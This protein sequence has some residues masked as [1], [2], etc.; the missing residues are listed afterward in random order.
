[1]A[2]S[3]KMG[4]GQDSWWRRR[5]LTGS[6]EQ[7][8]LAVLLLL[9]WWRY[10]PHSTSVCPQQP[11]QT[12][13]SEEL[14]VSV[15][16]PNNVTPIPSSNTETEPGV[17]VPRPAVDSSVVPRHVWVAW[18]GP[19]MQGPRLEGFHE[20]RKNLGV[21][22]TVLTEDNL[23]SFNIKEDPM[24]PAVFENDLS[25]NHLVDYLRV[26][27]MHHYG[28]GYHDIKPNNGS[29]ARSFNIFEQDPNVWMYGI[30]E[31]GPYG[32]ACDPGYAASMNTT[33]DLV[34]A[35]WKGLACNGAYIMRPKT[36]MT[37]A[38]LRIVNERLSSKYEQL[39]K[40]PAPTPRCC[41]TWLGQ[42]AKGYPFQWA[43]MHGG[44]FHPVQSRYLGHIRHGL[45][46]WEMGVQYRSEQEV[47]DQYG[48][49]GI[50][51]AK[52]A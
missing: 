24:H 28:G 43:E 29:W 23:A 42:D 48:Q 32:V 50:N 36:A 18:F 25:K 37:A 7:K 31:F 27:F 10:M 38:W 40:H 34:K 15:Q 12:V 1:M 45:H 14:A 20:L 11:S 19:P 8:L 26:Y 51:D 33:C 52:K 4:S 30:H 21:N 35:S 46:P 5:G 16:P 2:S 3:M 44:A 9:L 41:T 49:K 39:K 47:L 22:M 6:T 17:Y 13:S